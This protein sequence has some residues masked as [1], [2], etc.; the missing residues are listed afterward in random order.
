[1]KSVH[2]YIANQIKRSTAGSIL[3]PSDFRGL[4]ADSAIKMSL[5][6]HAR[7][8]LLVRLAHGIYFKEKKNNE[9]IKPSLEEIAAAIAKKEKIK[10]KPSNAFALYHLGLADMP[11]V[12]LTYITDGEPRNILIAGQRLIFKSATPKKLSLSSRTCGLLIQALEEIGQNSVTDAHR[13]EIIKKMQHEDPERVMED[14]R[15]AP[16]WIYNMLYKLKQQ[17]NY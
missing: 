11:P 7:E 12:D 16:S 8:G 10:I 13:T 14:L 5:S 2:R 3:F 6:R 4:G 17:I 9:A 15:L 1:M